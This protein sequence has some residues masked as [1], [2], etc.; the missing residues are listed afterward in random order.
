MRRWLFLILLAFALPLDSA[1]QII[2][3]FAVFGGYTYAHNKY[4][5]SNTGFS[6]NGWDG[7]FEVKP[8]PFIS[9]VGD[10]S[11]QYGSPGGVRENQTSFLVGPQL[12]VPGIKNVIP[13]AH[14]MAGVVHGT[15]QQPGGCIAIPG[16]TC[17]PFLTGNTFAT[18][19]GGG[20]DF[21]LKGPIWVR[22][23]QIDWLHANLN[24]DH[25]AQMRLAT[26]IV[27][28]FGK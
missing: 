25:H 27:I 22:A 11:K 4:T 9:L 8:L 24:P 2:P 13:F 3:H 12:S 19:V 6:L 15:T 17:P 20:V 21:K 5:G 26:G 16:V 14:A 1:G 18:A 28:R 7:S 23:V 10:L